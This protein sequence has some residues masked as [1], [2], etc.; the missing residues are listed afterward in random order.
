MKQS[1][2]AALRM[3]AE[4]VRRYYDDNTRLFLSLGQGTEGT[5]HRAIWGHGVETRAEAMRYVDGL[6]IERLRRITD[7]PTGEPLRVADLGCGVCSSLCYIAERLSILGTGVTISPA[8]VALATERISARGLAD[9]IRCVHGD[10][11]NLPA[12][13]PQV[14]LAFGIESFI[15]APDAAAFFE[16]C[17]RLIRPGGY[18]I[19]CD[20][21]LANPSVR[22]D[23]RASGW[24]ER[25]RR[26]WKGCN[27]IAESEATTLAEGVGF[28]HRETLDMGPFLEIRRPRDYAMAALMRCFGW[29]PVKGSYWSML[30][31][32]H[33]LQLSL[34]R[35]WIKHLVLVWQRQ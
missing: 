22:D 5:I 8:Q 20:D 21:L 15:H 13:L 12:G 24:L 18:L 14:D 1:G 4:H 9:K 31:G 17:A 25:V 19:V 35:G 27:L 16:Q 34:E 30:Y 28:K 2:T 32:G 26:G 3:D 33:A 11:C 10:F 6:V 7:V 29:L 23:R